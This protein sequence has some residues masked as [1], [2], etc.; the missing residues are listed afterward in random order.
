MNRKLNWERSSMPW[1]LPVR[2]S[3]LL[4][5]LGVAHA[6]VGVI[7]YRSELAAVASDGVFN[8][9]KGDPER[10][11]A[12]WFLVVAPALWMSG[13]LFAVAESTGHLK[14]QVVAG[15]VLIGLGLVGVLAMPASPFWALG[16]VGVVALRNGSPRR[17]PTPETRRHDVT[18][19]L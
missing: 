7:K 9:V 15:R 3:G 16:A 13:R 2:A 6:A 10:L 1:A 4:Q 17:S 5:L 8:A 14:V 19:S 12:F 11:V 18:R